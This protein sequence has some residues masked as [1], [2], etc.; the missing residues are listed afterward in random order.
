MCRLYCIGSWAV[1]GAGQAACCPALQWQ[2]VLGE[3]FDE[4]LAQ[5]ETAMETGLDFQNYAMDKHI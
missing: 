3:D 4:C 2:I 5:T 1:R